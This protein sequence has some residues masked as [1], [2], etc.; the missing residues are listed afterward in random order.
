MGTS[1]VEVGIYVKWTM[2]IGSV[3]VALQTFTVCGLHICDP[4]H[5]GLRRCHNNYSDWLIDLLKGDGLSSCCEGQ[6]EANT[7]LHT[8]LIFYLFMHVAVLCMSEQGLLNVLTFFL[9]TWH[10]KDAGPLSLRSWDNISAGII[11]PWHGVDNYSDWLIDLLK[12]DGLSGCCAWWAIRGKYI[13]THTTAI[14]PLHA[15]MLCS[16]HV[17]ASKGCLM[18]SR[19][20]CWLDT[21]RT[22]A[23]S[24]SG[25]GTTSV[26]ASSSPD[27]VSQASA[28]AGGGAALGAMAMARKAELSSR[29]REKR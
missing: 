17:R 26:Q 1:R 29:G 16:L 21:A 11:I 25:S 24:A 7:H 6:W 4:F 28:V 23:P 19:S 22:R 5:S 13:L 10:C 18:C 3:C 8:W 14:L 9:L 15:C 27:M 12:G 20:S 2:N